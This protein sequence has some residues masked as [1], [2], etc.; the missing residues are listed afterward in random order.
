MEF[1]ECFIAFFCFCQVYPLLQAFINSFPNPLTY[2]LLQTASSTF[3]DRSATCC[4]TQAA[5]TTNI[6]LI[7]FL[8]SNNSVT[9]RLER[10][11]L[12]YRF[13]SGIGASAQSNWLSNPTSWELKGEEE[14]DQR[15]L[16]ISD[17]ST[18]QQLW[19]VRLESVTRSTST[20]TT[21]ILR[22]PLHSKQPTSS[23]S[24]FYLSFLLLIVRYKLY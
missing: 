9:S 18:T 7:G 23:H 8:S 20:S 2:W 1:E 24:Y 15:D 10:D 4:L 5:D 11:Y 13:P 22:S 19:P 12:L 17:G 16:S 3:C 21:R 14:G 6:Y